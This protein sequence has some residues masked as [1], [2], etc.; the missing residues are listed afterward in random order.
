MTSVMSDLL[1]RERPALVHVNNG[2][3]PGA[4]S[5]LAAIRAAPVGAARVMTVNNMAYEY[6]R[7]RR[8]AAPT[9]RD[10]AG[11][12][13]AAVTASQAAA[14]RLELTV[15]LSP[16]TVHSIPNT[17]REPCSPP[18]GVDAA[19]SRWNLDD[20]G[21]VVTCVARLEP[22]KGHDVLLRAWPLIAA[23]IP[24][25][26]L[27]LA[28]DGPDFRAISEACDLLRAEGTDVRCLGHVSEIWSLYEASDLVLLPSTGQ[29][30]MPLTLIEA[31]CAGRPVIASD[32]AGAREVVAEGVTGLLVPP[33]EVEA[34]TS[35]VCGL[36]ADLT[37]RSSMG[38]ATRTRYREHFAHDV[39]TERYGSVWEEAVE[40]SQ[41]VA[42]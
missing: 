35:A 15:G 22:R 11:S 14:R 2:G 34:L 24:R 28:G 27:M 16:Q 41:H 33:G 12:L 13:H 17:I 37:R 9:E 8:L 36:A 7:F 42:Q 39:W 30:D 3:W 4:L 6:R 21:F 5:C 18:I 20:R 40:A 25:A 32:V 19:R 10:I 38:L 1:A 23:A 26:S 29:E 31:A